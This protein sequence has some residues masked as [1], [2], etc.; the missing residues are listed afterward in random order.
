MQYK[1]VT[2]EDIISLIE[3]CG[4]ENVFVQKEIHEDYSHD[5]LQGL[6]TYP[7][8]LITPHSEKE[9]SSVLKYASENLIPVTP[10]GRGT[11][12]VGGCVSL[13]NGILLSCHRMNRILELDQENLTLTVEAGAMLL[14]INQFLA[15]TNYFYAPDPG[16]KSASLGGNISTNAG[17][18][19][20]IKYGVTR[21]S[22]LGLEVVLPDG[23]ILNFGGK[24]VKNSSGYS[25]KDLIIGSE[26]TL[27]VITKA[28]LKLRPKPGKIINLLVPYPD[29][30]TA[31][32][33]VPE[34]MKTKTTPTAVEFM[35]KK[36]ILTAEE[37]LG[38]H[39]PDKS[40][41]AY[42]LITFDG[43]D[44]GE[45]EKIY[46]E[47]A[48]VCLKTG[49]YDVF[50]S[51]TEERN[52]AIWSARGA[53]LEAIKAST[54]VLD[55]CDVVVPR[56]EI[57]AFVGFTKAL[58]KKYGLRILTFGHAG[59]GN[60]HSYILKDDCAQELW[61]NKIQLI[62]NELYEQATSVGGQISGEHGIGYAK[63]DFLKRALC[64]GTYELMKKI[65][66]C[67]DPNNILNPGKV[68]LFKGP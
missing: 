54:T 32:S 7:S 4:K 67:F 34:I 66:G 28:I 57:A 29:I 56:K 48:R 37:Y 68:I 14:D 58:E 27:A 46:D 39:F 62:F 38:K 31:I 17:G 23:Q 53:F 22:V 60:I 12:L 65:K 61:E 18:M 2:K 24:T 30:A 21:D 13:A 63:R 51:D 50:I 45:I 35:E 64:P 3:I 15:D 42:L 43:I 47:A 52:E 33:A 36:V 16:E 59:D 49:A 26:G 8:V 19:R 1:K 9:I 41:D 11:G 44:K 40:A 55:E 25:I 20:A 5:E 6:I 10:R